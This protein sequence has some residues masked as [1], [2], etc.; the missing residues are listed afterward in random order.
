MEN[1][2]LALGAFV[3]AAMAA[4][5]GFAAISPMDDAAFILD[6]R[7]AGG[8]DANS[9]GNALDFSSTSSKRATSVLQNTNAPEKPCV[10]NLAV[11]S[12]MYPADTNLVP[13]LYLPTPGYTTVDTDGTTH[14]WVYRQTVDIQ[15]GATAKSDTLTAYVRFRWDGPTAT[16]AINHPDLMIIGYHSWS[17]PGRGLVLHGATRGENQSIMNIGAY[18]PKRVPGTDNSFSVTTNKWYDLFVQ[19]TPSGDN[20]VENFY[21]CETPYFNARTNEPSYFSAPAF[22]RRHCADASLPK[23]ALD[24]SACDFVR[25][26]AEAPSAAASDRNAGD[27]ATKCFR[28]AIARAAYW[29]R[30]LTENEM[31]EVMAADMA[32]G[33]PIRAGA[34][35]GTSEEFAV[36]GG[37]GVY[38]PKTMPW[39]TMRGELTAEHPAIEIEAPLAAPEA[40][41]PHF[42]SA[43]P[44]FVD[45]GERC[46][47]AIYVNGKLVE[48]VDLKTEGGLELPVAKGLVTRT[49]SGTVKVRIE[50]LAPISGTVKLD[51]ITFG[52]SWQMGTRN[53]SDG[54]FQQEGKEPNHFFVGDTDF[55]H[56]QRSVMGGT[57][58]S[59]ATNNY[60]HFYLP[61]AAVRKF[62]FKYDARVT[63]QNSE[64]TNKFG[65]GIQKIGLFV[66]GEETPRRTLENFTNMT[67]IATVTFAPGELKAGM[68][69]FHWRNL[70]FEGDTKT[71]L[72]IS[73]DYHRLLMDYHPGLSILLK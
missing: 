62:P 55:K 15:H 42:L 33:A 47:A 60:I 19:V 48:K 46:P 56:Y 73:F 65:V 4:L 64:T 2:K 58:A 63:F 5:G 49:A 32:R 45:V 50:R 34:L 30:T 22:K 35:N 54:E 67:D 29:T 12:P 44:I 28:G 14:Y 68:N 25:F 10:T 41:L 23:L 40:K 26:G 69:T 1:R 37:D 7:K 24:L 31:W 16:S 8:I 51:A 38:N 18:I 52:G 11:A 43:K 3:T 6:L 61:E 27:A 21:L 70:R 57:S 39:R 17:Y 72:Y 59:A 36:D 9:A 71:L 66:N 13:C 20:S 53:A